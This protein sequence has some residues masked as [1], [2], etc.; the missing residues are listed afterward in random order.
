MA[1]NP[2]HRRVAAHNHNFMTLFSR[3]H[4]A[5]YQLGVGLQWETMQEELL[6]C[7]FTLSISIV[8]TV[9][10][11]ASRNSK[12]TKTTAVNM[13]YYVSGHILSFVYI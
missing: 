3:S 5:P 6:A 2:I 4:V 13:C 10:L 9:T 12:T 11:A 8:L 7:A 1:Y